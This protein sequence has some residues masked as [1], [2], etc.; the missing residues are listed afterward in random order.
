[1]S[2]KWSE[3]KSEITKTSY[4]KFA[5]KKHTM[6][7]RHYGFKSQHDAREYALRFRKDETIIGFGYNKRDKHFY[8]Y[9][10]V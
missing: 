6:I 5:Q 4:R 7:Y 9:T 10:L 1:M 3:P 2:K 8:E